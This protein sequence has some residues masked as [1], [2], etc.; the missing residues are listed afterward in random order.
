[1]CIT[2]SALG[3]AYHIKIQPKTLKQWSKQNI[4]TL[5]VLS[6]VNRNNCIPRIHRQCQCYTVPVCVIL[7]CGVSVSLIFTVTHTVVTSGCYV[8]KLD[9]NARITRKRRTC[10]TLLHTVGGLTLAAIFCTI[11]KTTTTTIAKIIRS[12]TNTGVFRTGFHRHSEESELCPGLL[13]TIEG[14]SK[15]STTTIQLRRI[16][17]CIKHYIIP[18]ISVSKCVLSTSFRSFSGR[19]VCYWAH[20]RLLR[21]FILCSTNQS[22]FVPTQSSCRKSPR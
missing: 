1:M 13:D 7:Y 5:N 22:T 11:I 18:C 2:V 16:Q 15:P 19:R 14:Y 20:E 21:R 8:N 12:I 9:I 3:I 17:Q 6:I 4:E 10:P